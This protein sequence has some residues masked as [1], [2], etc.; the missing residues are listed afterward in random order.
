M[1]FSFSPIG[2]LHTD[3]REKFGVPRQ[4]LMVSD[5]RGTLKLN[6]DPNYRA[7]LTHLETFTHVWV[8]FVFHK[9][10]ERPWVAVTDPPRAGVV[11]DLGVFASRSP[12]RPN[13]IGLSV[14]KLEG[15][16]YQA[17]GGIEI[18]FSG[19]DILDGT[20]VLDIKPYVPYADRIEEA[21]AGWAVEDKHRYAVS[22]SPE[23]SRALDNQ[24]DAARLKALITQ[25]L[26]N[27]PR[28]SGQRR[29]ST[30]E[31]LGSERKQFAFR[32]L[33]LDIHWEV[34]E[35]VLHVTN[36]LTIPPKKPSP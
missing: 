36:I 21:G 7:A 1:N 2:I 15:I 31:N 20:P 23:S 5:A 16:N 9:E 32:L 18:Q 19:V 22:F 14:L 4:S 35:G 8:V 33:D 11:K 26:E 12:R 30:I 13:P 34:R 24:A 28:P 17:A 3:F 25:I 10:L 27:D 6:P 29:A